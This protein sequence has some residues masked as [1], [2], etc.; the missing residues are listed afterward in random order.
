MTHNI[1]C[2]NFP[3]THE[4]VAFFNYMVNNIVWEARAGSGGIRRS[5]DNEK[6]GLPVSR[7][8]GRNGAAL[9]QRGKMLNCGALL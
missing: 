7:K 5:G 6:A 3:R 4:S 9:C 8:P 1:I 2:F